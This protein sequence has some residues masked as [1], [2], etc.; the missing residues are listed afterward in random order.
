VRRLTV[1]HAM[2]TPAVS[3]MMAAKRALER[4]TRRGG[5]PASRLERRTDFTNFQMRKVCAA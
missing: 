1:H 3:T 4:G 2:E 5:G